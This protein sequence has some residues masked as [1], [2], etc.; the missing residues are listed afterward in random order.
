MHGAVLECALDARDVRSDADVLCEALPVLALGGEVRIVDEAS[1]CGHAAHPALGDHIE[2][3][4]ERQRWCA[5][6]GARG[7]GE[8]QKCF[9][10]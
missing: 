6:A 4:V 9:L 1:E 5:D 7:V 8:L 3:T 2:V 10:R